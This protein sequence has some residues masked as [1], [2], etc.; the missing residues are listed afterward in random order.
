MYWQEDT[1]KEQCSVPDNVVD[2]VYQIRC[3]TLPVDHAWPLASEIKKALPWFPEEPLAGLHLIHVADSGNGW[4]RPQGEGEL[5]YPSRRTRLVLRIPKQRLD[6]AMALVTKTLDIAGHPLK[7]E[8]AK[9]R[10]LGITDILYSRYVISEPTWS[11]TE[12]I[13][14]TVTQLKTMHVSFKKILGG[15]TNR[16]ATPQGALMTRSLMVA[17]LSFEDAIHLQE[18]GIGEGRAMGCGLFIP[19]KSF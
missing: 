5:L 16:L 6:D 1:S 19:Q 17:N 12:F 9:S 13:D 14:W 8:S 3:S 11:E 7:V 15:K 18:Q 2:L 4:E 10:Q